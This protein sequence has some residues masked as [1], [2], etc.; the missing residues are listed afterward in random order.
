L[1]TGDLRSV[2]LQPH[3]LSLDLDLLKIPYSS[4]EISAL[5]DEGNAVLIDTVQDSYNDIG[6]TTRVRNLAR[7]LAE[8][9]P[10]TFGLLKCRGVIKLPSRPLFADLTDF[11][12]IFDIPRGLSNPRSL[13]ELLSTTASLPLDSRLELAKK[14]ASSILFLHT[15]QFLHKSIRPE[16]II[17]FKNEYSG[18]VAP[19]LTGF[20]QF[21]S[22]DTYPIG[23][24]NWK[25]NICKFL[26]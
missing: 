4:V 13:R 6:T 17:V 15:V 9:D 12:F 2:W 26:S 5:K 10:F 25:H 18:M 22:S 7:V 3:D 21:S 20:E 8:V 23:D 19:F 1:E 11:K 24:D 14:L 16:T